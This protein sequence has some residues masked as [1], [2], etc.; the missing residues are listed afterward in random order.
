MAWHDIVRSG[1]EQHAI[2]QHQKVRYGTIRGFNPQEREAKRNDGTKQL[3]ETTW[4]GMTLHG[5][6]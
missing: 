1:T 2:A 4:H 5:M 3:R 6:V